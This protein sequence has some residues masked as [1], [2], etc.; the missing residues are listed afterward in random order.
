MRARRA[1]PAGRPD[2][3]G[4][5]HGRPAGPSRRRPGRRPAHHHPAHRA[6]CPVLLAPAMHTEM[7]EHPATVANVATLRGARR[8][9]R[10]DPRSR[11]AD[12]RRHRPGPAARAR[13]RSLAGCALR[14]VADAPAAAGPARAGTSS[15]PP[16]AP[17]SRSTPCASS[18]T[19]PPAGRASRS[20]AAARARGAGSTLVAAHIERARPRRRRRRPGRD[21]APSCGSRARRGRRTPTSSSW[22]PPSP[23]SGRPR[24]PDAKIKK[25]PTMAPTALELVADR[26]HPRRAG[27]AS[28]RGRPG[29]RR[30]RRRDRA[31]RP[32]T[33]STTAGR[34][35][36]R[37]GGD[38]LVVNEVG[39]G[40]GSAPTRN[41]VVDP[42]RAGGESSPTAVGQQGRRSPTPSGTPSS[43]APELLTRAAP[44]DAQLRCPP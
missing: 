1:R 2:R 18:A 35:S 7:W 20:A 42:R 5:G 13:R 32:A 29:R 25:Q 37:K 26:R 15:S 33:C 36:P 6:R 9:R 31:T 40:A 14:R 43:H 44:C 17:A 4:A 8:A 30:L 19:G 27:G 28:R 23:T 10:S 34:S 11:A 3:R 21:A 16:A 38:L 24:A 12:R 39:D 22:P 41:A